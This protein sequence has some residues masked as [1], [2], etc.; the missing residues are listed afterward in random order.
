M[1]KRQPNSKQCFVC[2]VANPAGLKIHF[3]DN[4]PGEVIADYTVPV[5][6]QGYP[7]IVHGGI[8]AAMLDEISGRSHMS[9]GE[10][11]RFMYT[12]RLEVRYR[13][14]VPVG[15]PLR[16]VGKAG[17]KRSKLATASAAIYDAEGVLLAESEALLV[18]VSSEVWNN[19]D[20][21]L[22]GWKVYEEP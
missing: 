21:E 7:G 20:L 19:V 1:P 13:K 8:V 4:T 22:L 2:G 15:K 10:Q 9:G 3:Y 12:A 11:P 6:Y 18:E 14:H 5:E 17:K 16:L